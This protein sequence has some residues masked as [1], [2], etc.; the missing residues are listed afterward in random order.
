M[1]IVTIIS[2]HISSSVC[3]TGWLRIYYDNID[4]V[5][6]KPPPPSDGKCNLHFGF[7]PFLREAA[8]PVK[9]CKSTSKAEVY[10]CVVL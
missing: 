10:S 5:Y 4:C 3:L 2:R 1:S 8:F 6:K 7:P 9:S